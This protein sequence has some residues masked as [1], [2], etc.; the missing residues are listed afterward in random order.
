LKRF[1]DES[2]QTLVMMAL[3]MTVLL[4]FLGFATDVGVMLHEKRELQSAADSAALAGA[5]REKYGPVAATTAALNDASLNGFTDGSNGVTV[6]VKNPP[7]ASEVQNSYFT[8][9]TYV[10]VTISQSTPLNFM[11]LFNSSALAIQARAIAGNSSPVTDCVYILNQTSPNAMNLQGSFDVSTPGCG[12]VVDSNSPSA[13]YL[14]GNSGTLTAGSVSVVG[15]AT[16]QLTDSV[17]LPVT[18]ASYVDDPF[19]TLAAPE[20]D[21]TSVPCSTSQP[22][23]GTSTNPVT[24]SNPG[25]VCYKIAGDITLSNV[26][27]SPGVY[28]FDNP[29]YNLKFNGSVKGSGVTLYLLGGLTTP[30]STNL[31][32]N[33]PTDPSAQYPGIIIYAAKTDSSQL[34]FSLGNATGEMTGIIYAPDSQLY[35]QDSGSGTNGL[36]LTTDL[37]V[38]TLYDKTATLVIKSYIA[39]AGANISPLTHPVLVQ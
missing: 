25:T 3:S 29:G 28:V 34:N 2:G 21:D 39:T 30:T 24:I 13:L 20:Y 16:G 10:E 22:S 19:A 14:G 7:P 23:S 11:R 32:L 12:V 33:A 15:G 38:N 31:Q 35:L 9:T 1:G 37:I 6:T 18:G 4:G 17:P 27:L 5:T 36:S 8:T 26:T